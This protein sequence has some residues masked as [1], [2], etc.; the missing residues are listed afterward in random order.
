MLR[1]VGLVLF[2]A[3]V[4]VRVGDQFVATLTQGDGLIWMAWATLITLVPVLT[5][6]IVARAVYRV[7]YPSLCGLLVGSMTGA[8]ALS[9]ATDLTGSE[10]PNIS[11]A[12]VYPLVMLLRVLSAQAIVMLLVR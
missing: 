5:V 2:L 11:Y 10:A 8:P 7:D 6:G 4:G 1:E 12:T 3:C 9:F